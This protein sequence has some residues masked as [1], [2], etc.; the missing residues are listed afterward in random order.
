MRLAPS[1]RPVQ[2]TGFSTRRQGFKSPWGYFEMTAGH[3]KMEQLS[4]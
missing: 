2:D 4:I 1:S 3:F